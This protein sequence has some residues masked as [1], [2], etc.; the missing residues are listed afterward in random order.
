MTYTN[1]VQDNFADKFY[2]TFIAIRN[3][4]TGKTRLVEANEIVLKPE[5][6]YPKSKNPVLLQEGGEKKTLEEKIEASKHLIKSF[7]QSK[8]LIVSCMKYM[9]MNLVE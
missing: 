1:S 3:K 9:N 2:T 7:G 6:T 8:E 4:T 5:V